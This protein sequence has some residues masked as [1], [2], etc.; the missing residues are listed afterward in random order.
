MLSLR[1]PDTV[2]LLLLVQTQS[3][4]EIKFPPSFHLR[5]ATYRPTLNRSG[6]SHILRTY[7]GL[8]RGP[9]VTLGSVRQRDC[10]TGKKGEALDERK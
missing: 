7:T 1:F 10:Y 6:L 5:H 4:G 3:W 8:Y 9:E 2:Y